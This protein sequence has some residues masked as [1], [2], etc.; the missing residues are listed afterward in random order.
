[1]S[2]TIEKVIVFLVGVSF[3]LGVIGGIMFG[4]PQYQVWRR[5]KAG[6]A[7]LSEAEFSKK[8][9][10]EQAKADLESAKL[11]AQAEIERAKGLRKSIEIISGGLK[12]NRE[13]IQY[14]AIQAQMK[15]AES[16]NHS[17]IYIPVGNLGIPLIKEIEK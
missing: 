16:Q 14:L 13:Y 7:Q 5:A 1:M 12:D 3:I 10:I 8:V 4:I 9:Q 11:W 6:Q 15:M 17:T 2:E